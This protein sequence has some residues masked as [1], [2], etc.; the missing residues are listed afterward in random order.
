MR[1]ESEA[2]Y[3]ARIVPPSVAG[4]GFNR[5]NLIKAALGLSA[6]ATM[7]GLLAACGGGDDET[8]GASGES[9]VAARRPGP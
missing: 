1:P 9:T 6:A 5:R 7:P 2:E 8:G 4:T 3:L